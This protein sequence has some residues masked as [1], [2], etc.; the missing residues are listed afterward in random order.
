MQPWSRRRLGWLLLLVVGA[1]GVYFVFG[2]SDQRDA[3]G[4]LE[5]LAAAGSS[6]PGETQSSWQTRLRA[7]LARRALPDVRLELPELEPLEGADAILELWSSFEGAQLRIKIQQ[8][9]VRVKGDH[10]QATL[11]LAVTL[12]YPGSELRQERTVNAD[13]VRRNGHFIVERLIVSEPSHAQP[14]PRP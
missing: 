11:E 10:A 12:R 3:L 9:D 14:E 4:A 6:E 8:S 5:L 13:L 2:P 1:I 7:A